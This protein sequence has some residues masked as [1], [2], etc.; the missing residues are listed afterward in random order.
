M[1]N[2][3]ILTL[4]VISIFFICLF[5]GN[6]SARGPTNDDIG[7]GDV[8]YC[9][10]QNLNVTTGFPS[11]LYF[12]IDGGSEVIT[13]VANKIS[14]GTT[15][16]KGVYIAYYTPGVTSTD[17]IVVKDLT[18]TLGTL[19][20]RTY[21]TDAPSSPTVASGVSTIQ[22]D[23]GIMYY[24]SG[25]EIELSVLPQTWYN[26]TITYADGGTTETITNLAGADVQ[27]NSN[28]NPSKQTNALAFKFRDNNPA[29]QISAV[30][31]FKTDL[32]GLIHEKQLPITINTA[33]PSLTSPS[34]ILQ[35][36][37]LNLALFGTPY[38][39]YTLSI[40]PALGVSGPAFSK[41]GTYD[42]F[43]QQKVT[44][45]TDWSGTK[46]IYVEIPSNATLG[47][48]QIFTTDA[49][50]TII[51][52]LSFT[53]EESIRTLTF[54]SLPPDAIAGKFAVGDTILLQGSLTN[55]K[56]ND[57][58]YL[59]LTGANLPAN[60]ASLITGT[61]VVDGS[62]ATFTQMDLSAG[63][64][65]H[66]WSTRGLDSGTYTLHLN[67][68]PIGAATEEGL[69]WSLYL[70]EASIHLTLADETRN[71]FVQG[72]PLTLEW[73]A[74]GS[75]GAAT[76]LS[77]SGEV[78]WYI[79]GTNYNYA[80]KMSNFP[81]LEGTLGIT[82][83]QGK[84]N[85]SYNKNMTKG[86]DLGTYNLIIQH[87]GADNVFDVYPDAYNKSFSTLTTSQGE[88]TSIADK[89]TSNVVYLLESMLRSSFSDDLYSIAEFT[90]EKPWFAIT[91]ITNTS[92]G[93]PLTFTGTTNIPKGESVSLIIEPLGFNI[94]TDANTAMRIPT[95]K[96]TTSPGSDW[97]YRTF[98][99]KNIDTTTW[100]PGTYQAT[101]IL[102]DCGMKRTTSF[103]ITGGETTVVNATTTA[104]YNTD[105]LQTIPTNTQPTTPSK[106]ISTETPT[107]SPIDILG[108]IAGLGVATYLIRRK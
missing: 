10:E 93:S 18:E 37:T 8:I 16:T 5:T 34:T 1:N 7:N 70:S 96:T 25:G 98:S 74:R 29:S 32:N 48:Y 42:S 91:D 102:D 11:V 69:T 44:V 50:G 52:P 36:E 108:I 28:N 14:I 31:T 54:S 76:N 67:S 39:I 95:S 38:T 43:T 105:L 107:K 68:E 41:T 78:H 89:Q 81:I 92:I 88:T 40:D 65:S 49:A 30:L 60:G 63:K 56:A 66:Y 87:P 106:P 35:G 53:V 26:Y 72:S 21:G 2:T 46:T 73:I 4:L 47:N 85:Y 13:P 57:T 100:Y 51:A 101:I 22:K 3:K 86:L 79:F 97:T 27:L 71:T 99:F 103:S 75:P 64:F 24:F 23:L 58:A 12:R 19:M 45:H 59:Y 6:V 33:S 84:Y 80:D 82:A 77:T 94:S 61:P 15:Q 20:I 9:G 17:Y 90:I 104:D 62:V 55:A 83:P